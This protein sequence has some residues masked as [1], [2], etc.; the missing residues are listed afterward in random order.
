MNIQRLEKLKEL[1]KKESQASLKVAE[2]R[3]E[4]EKDNVG[5]LCRQ[6]DLS[7]DIE[8]V[9]IDIR[10]EAEEEFLKTNNKKL[11]GGIGIRVTTSYDYEESVAIKWALEKMPVA[12]KQII[13]KKM[14]KSYIKDNSLE[15]VD[16]QSKI[17]VTF[18]KI[19]VL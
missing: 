17:V 7:R 4:W 9:K 19:I 8:K 3:T 13:D 14:F 10:L 6:E 1:I 11:T 5:L 2:L 12:V 18:P 16:E 15:F